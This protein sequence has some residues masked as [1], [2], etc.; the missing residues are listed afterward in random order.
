L[1]CN[2]CSKP[3][4]QRK[5]QFAVFA[6]HLFLLNEEKYMSKNLLSNPN[7]TAVGPNGI[8]T[9][10]TGITSAGSSAAADWILYNNS[11]GIIETE[12]LTGSEPSGALSLIR[13]STTGKSN[14]LVQVFLPFDTGPQATISSAWVYVVRGQVGIGVGNGGG[15][16]LD[17]LSTSTGRWELL[18][19]RNGGS[20]ANEFIIYAASDD[21]AIFYVYSAEVV[22]ASV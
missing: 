9:T 21:G 10:F 19:A 11:E 22:E 7:F 13:V 8:A 17:A 6:F 4:L 5:A 15:T 2:Q 1:S 14:G 20:P 3:I 16:G 12:L 18:K